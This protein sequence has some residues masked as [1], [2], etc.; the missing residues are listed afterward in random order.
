[1]SA[2]SVVVSDLAGGA[3]SRYVLGGEG[4]DDEWHPDLVERDEPA[5]QERVEHCASEGRH[6]G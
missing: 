2:A 5:V 4:G 1:L 3:M 6:Q